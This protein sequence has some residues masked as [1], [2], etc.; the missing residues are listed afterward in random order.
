[1]CRLEV[2]LH[3]LIKNV[4]HQRAAD[5]G[6]GLAFLCVC[7]ST[8]GDLRADHQFPFFGSLNKSSEVVRE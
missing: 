8:S 7:F 2:V 3:P 6:R 4:H 1:M 5:D